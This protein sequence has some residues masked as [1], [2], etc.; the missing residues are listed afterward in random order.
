MGNLSSIRPYFNDEAFN[1][2]EELTEMTSLTEN[3]QRMCNAEKA[4]MRQFVLLAKEN[5]VPPCLSPKDMKVWLL[6]K[7][8]FQQEYQEMQM[9]MDARMFYM[10]QVAWTMERILHLN[11]IQKEVYTE[12]NEEE[13]LSRLLE[14]KVTL[15][16]L[17]TYLTVLRPH[18]ERDTETFLCH[19]YKELM[20]SLEK[21]KMTG[22]QRLFFYPLFH[23]ATGTLAQKI[24]ELA[25]DILLEELEP[26]GNEKPITATLSQ[27][28]DDASKEIG[29]MLVDALASIPVLHQNIAR[30]DLARMCLDSAW[31]MVQS[32]YKNFVE[33]SENFHPMDCDDTS[34]TARCGVMSAIVQM[35]YTCSQ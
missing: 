30:G 32:I 25:L 19:L 35:V 10:L 4:F 34:V 1:L 31:K 8:N 29:S 6:K 16:G 24:T 18:V 27:R 9:R 20:R 5:R 11:R 15:Q 3:E 17:D 28:A 7:R 22:V 12:L 33:G 21:T 13:R 14:R 26:P 2:L 23:R